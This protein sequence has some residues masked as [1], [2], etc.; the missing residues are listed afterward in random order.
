MKND[1]KAKK[2]RIDADMKLQ[3]IIF[4]LILVAL[5]F[6]SPVNL[7][8]QTNKPDVHK[9][10]NLLKNAV[11]SSDSI[12]VLLDV[13]SISD[14]IN[15]AKVRSQLINLAQRS[16]NKEVIGEVLRELSTS[17]DD[18]RDLSR[19]IE[20]SESLP[21]GNGK[22]TVQTVL[23]ME[24]AQADAVD[25]SDSQVKDQ[26]VENTRLAIS[27]NTDPYKE[28]QNLYRA[29]VYLGTASQ[30]PLYLEYVKRMD[31][32]VNALP[33]KDHA[34][35]NLFYTTAA[36][37][38]TR[39]RDYQEAI[40]YDRKLIKELDA[41]QNQH[42]IRKDSIHDLDY[43]YYVSYR[44]MLRN[45][46]GLSQEEIEDLYQKCV[47]L[48][49]EDSLVNEAFGN[50]GL[51]KSYYYVGT[52]QFDKAVPELHKALND[53]TISEFR[54]QELLGLL[55]WSLNE[56][57]DQK[58]EL[59]TLREYTNMMMADQEKRREA[60][61]REIDLRNSVNKLINDEYQAQEA[62]RE[63]N[64][65][66]RKTSL[67]LVYVLGL[68]LIFMCQAYFRLRYKVKDLEQRNSKLRTNIEHIF[69]D[70]RPKGTRDIRHSKNRLK[71]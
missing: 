37:F 4:N 42:G 38:Y 16:D 23:H 45:F 15:R 8:G 70:G 53:S 52:R 26:I 50:G 12:K 62:Q 43:F 28:I 22:S 29:M 2:L 40:N 48:A 49:E 47:Q 35:K 51:T 5:F 24:Q 55:A 66:M 65:V 56:T 27:M 19:L 63:E 71:G 46:M 54:R 61:Y 59:L 20:I 10:E 17:T 7:K 9:K 64:R 13:Y 14:K 11:N 30:G 68:I 41:I 60:T 34:I 31:E 58:N 25:V 18:T 39:K 57:G 32:L 3:K 21:E 67:T 33:E 6:G 69:D 1:A 36:L 44:R